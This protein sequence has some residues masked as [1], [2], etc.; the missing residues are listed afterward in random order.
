MAERGP[1][2]RVGGALLDA[3]LSRLAEEAMAEI[4]RGQDGALLVG[5]HCDRILDLIRLMQ[6]A[7]REAR[8]DA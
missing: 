8:T 2:V 7:L 1:D 3:E 4:E 6:D 5:E